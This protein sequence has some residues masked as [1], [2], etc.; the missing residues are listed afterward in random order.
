M[1]FLR[2]L[3]LLPFAAVVSALGLSNAQAQQAETP[4]PERR[5]E[6]S[7]NTDFFG[8]D[9]RNVFD[10]S[11]ND[12]VAEC[13]GDPA[14]KAFTYNQKSFACF[15]KSA[16]GERTV[17]DG[18]LSVEVYD[19]SDDAVD[20]AFTR[21]GQLSILP[22]LY[23]KQA[24]HIA[25]KNG[26]R[27]PTNLWTH[28]ALMEE[29]RKEEAAGRVTR[30]MELVSAALND[31]DRAGAW[32]E[33]A[34][35]ANKAKTN[36]QSSRRFVREVR[37]AAAVNGFLRAD[38]A[39]E[40]VNA[41]QELARGLE[42]ERQ[43][44]LTIPVLRLAQEITPRKDTEDA[45][46]RAISLFGFR[47]VNHTVDHNSAS[48]RV[49]AEFSEDLVKGSVEYSD[50]IGVD[51]SGISAEAEGRQL[52]VE[53][54][55]HGESYKIAFRKGLPS[56]QG[57]VLSKTV[58]LNVY[59]EDRDPVARFAGRSYLMPQRDGA[60]I[61]IITVNADQ[62]DLKIY[63]VGDRNLLR[64]LQDD[65]FAKPVSRWRLNTLSQV[66]GEQVWVG[67]AQVTRTLNQEVTT[68]LP[69]A[70]A[71]TRFEAGVYAMTARV[72]GA[73][74]DQDTV[75]TQ[76][77]IVSDIG[78]STMK[79]NDGIHVFTRSL[80]T[81]QAMGGATVQLISKSNVIL[82]EAVTDASGYAAFP[83]GLALGTGGA[84]PAVIT[85]QNGDD[86]AFIDQ[87][88]AEYDLSDRGVEGREPAKAI[89]VFL[90]TD[91]GAYR[92]GE[93]IHTTVL[94]RDHAA[95][96]LRG[97][98]LTVDL[99]RPDGV[100][101]KRQLAGEVANGGSVSS[102]ELSTTAA[103]GAWSLRVYADRDAPALVT[104]RI[105][106]EDF[107]PEKIDFDLAL[108][109]GPIYMSDRPELRIDARYL[110]GA[111]G[112]GLQVEGEV[113][114][115]AAQEM[116]DYPGYKFGAV[117]DVF[118]PRYESITRGETDAE[119][120]RTLALALP[121]VKEVSKPLE[122]AAVVRLRDGS[123]RPVERRT[124]APVLPGVP[125]I[126]VKPLFDGNVA[127]GTNAVFDVIAVDAA[128]ARM[129]MAEVRWVLN[130]LQTRYQWYRQYGQWRYEPTTRRTRI[131]DGDL[132]LTAAQA[133]QITAA[134]DW[135]QYEL[136]LVH[137][138]TQFAQT[139][140]RFNAGWYAS[141]SADDTPD[142]LD[143][144]VDRGAYSVGDNVVLRLVS[145]F[146]GVAQ[147]SVLSDRLI[148][149]RS[150]P[151]RKGANEVTLEVSEDWGAGAY[152]TASVVRG[153]DGGVDP[154][155]A[156]GLAFAKVDPG[157]KKLR[158][159]FLS[160]AEAQ[161]RS[162][163]DVALKVEGVQ[164]GETAHVT[165]AAVDVGVL[166]LTGF[167]TPSPD[168]H[169]FGQRKLGVELR[170]V[171]GRLIDGGGTVG[172]MRSG[173]DNG[174][175][176]GLQGPPPSEEVLAQ[177][178]G[179]LVVG[180]DGVVRH[181][182]DLPDFNGTV[183]VMAIAWSKTGVGHAQQDVLV[184][185]PVVVAAHAPRFMTPGDTSRVRLE[186]T[187][188]FGPAGDFEVT[189]GGTLGLTLPT[190]GTQVVRLEKGARQIISVPMTAETVGAQR[191]DVSVVAPDGRVMKK[192]ITIPVQWNDPE[193]T[194]QTRVAVGSGKSL[195]LDINMM[196]GLMDGTVR[197]TLAVGP[198]AR[199][200]APGLLMALDRY[201]YGCTEQVTS[202]AMP[203]LYFDQVS[204]ALGLGN[205]TNV[206]QR[207]DQA[208]ER[209]LGNQASNGA[210]GLWYPSS[211]DLWLD[212]Y[213]TD[214][215]SRA[216]AQGYAVPDL[217]FEKALNNLRNRVNYAADFE[218]GGE[219]IAYALMVLAREGYAAIGDLRYY[220]DTRATAFGS[221]MAQAQ[222]GAALASYGD[223]M[224]ADTMFRLADARLKIPENVQAWRHDYGS[225]L[226][227][228]AAVM[229][230][231]VDAG[232]DVVDLAS[233]AQTVSRVPV[234]R[235]STQE[236]VWSLM[237]VNALV[238]EGIAQGITL[239]GDTLQAPMV[240]TLSEADLIDGVALENGGAQDTTA[241]VSVFGV[242]S[243]PEPAGGNGYVI[244]RSYFTMD[245][246]PISLTEVAQ[247]MRVVALIEVQP[248]RDHQARLMVNDPLPAGMEIDNPNLISGGDI[249][250]LDWLNLNAN[251]QNSEFRTDRFLAAVDWGGRDA[252][253]MAYVMRAVSPGSFHHPAAI[254]ED[255]YRP[256]FQARTSVGR[257]TIK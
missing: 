68:A 173:G 100:L 233:L 120:S 254:V 128:G 172:R 191:F 199:F 87:A 186:M 66:L 21:A 160:D 132:N 230:L 26:A 240:R 197:A 126:G 105:L 217:A 179:A 201:P 198:L 65:L 7:D 81:A 181:S 111:V 180:S 243:E 148:E 103:R 139:S 255:M 203:L 223:Q 74:D 253:R 95:V 150:V 248:T 70:D 249:K 225:S 159:S 157:A 63:R 52:C 90:A 152:V 224:R 219:D 241:V 245:G 209:V 41:L 158:V 43:G 91:R 98:P 35:L 72:S 36:T 85:V 210:F 175:G 73:K 58:D 54:M 204:E 20:L 193:I 119:G 151:V 142:L 145:R 101:S 109:D 42:A 189:F 24:K 86:Y 75:A 135:G 11:F 104:R 57:E 192:G 6:V 67:T 99:V 202:R 123:G 122:M 182:F 183:R 125:L 247:N 38:G 227:D 121:A 144:A 37:V 234:A 25:A 62:V 19:A 110:F 211:G 3:K 33:L 30:A 92:P 146:E 178:S 9:L 195:T 161:P 79:G 221:A 237:A 49:C 138:G 156:L 134:V 46:D 184:R 200:D 56:A 205:R 77:F 216:K 162:A 16:V 27:Y 149:T 164:A 22:E 69:I 17:F 4:I 251:V 94:A 136:K 61:P 40:Q 39:Q 127:E 78:I 213:V 96:G 10:V 12:C 29:A 256:D 97:V 76:W 13:L 154:S 174:A 64:T 236:S 140:L 124:T 106:V 215:L 231:A 112:A 188:V 1:K 117:D 93:R 8:S 113:K 222:L 60:S 129:D 108:Q 83:A 226:R 218:D 114:L 15:P 88:A 168:G 45:L 84:A 208:I 47:I 167:K 155:R 50:F 196:A 89:D 220:S 48:P 166:N 206:A 185:D 118:R 153:M 137:K 18:A 51:L 147:V 176:A 212:S 31:D 71:L 28:D 238:K 229:S 82:G 55:R 14:C 214:F 130:R 171:Y 163:L 207:I 250:A 141:G 116:A 59:V 257:V 228:R 23:I 131:A 187:H 235:R 2:S 244:T 252:F 5:I 32:I 102:F 177:F 242:P 44:R 246:E 115:S 143:V 239:N 190:A 194:R 53:G 232:S 80:R 34:R 170:D 133:A 165:L 107:V 169:Y